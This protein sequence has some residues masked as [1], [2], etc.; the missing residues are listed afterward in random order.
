ME[1]EKASYTTKT[2]TRWKNQDIFEGKLLDNSTLVEKT[3]HVTVS[4]LKL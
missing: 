3:L 2:L 1:K 4:M